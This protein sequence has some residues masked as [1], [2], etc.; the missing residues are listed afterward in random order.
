MYRIDY[1]GQVLAKK[2]VDTSKA[3]GLNVYGIS[4]S[5]LLAYDDGSESGDK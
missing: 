2:I 1:D 4:S 3:T 5:C